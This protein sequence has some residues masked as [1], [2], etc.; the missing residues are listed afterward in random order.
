MASPRRRGGRLAA[1]LHLLLLALVA[2]SPRGVAAE[3]ARRRHQHHAYESTAAHCAAAGIEEECAAADAYGDA[4]AALAAHAAAMAAAETTTT[5]TIGDAEAADA[6]SSSS[7]ATPRA[8]RVGPVA[9]RLVALPDLHGDLD[10][11]RRSLILAR[12]I[13]TTSIEETSVDDDAW[14]GGE[15]ILV[16]TGDVL[17]RGDASVALMRLLDKVRSSITLVP[18]RPRRRGERRSLRTF[19][20]GASLR[21]SGSL[22]G[23]DPRPR[24]LSTPLLTPLNST[25]ASTRLLNKLARAAKDAGGEVVGLLGNHELMTLQGDLRYVSKRELV[26]LGKAALER[27]AQ[28]TGSAGARDGDAATQTEE[29]RRRWCD[30]IETGPHTTPHAR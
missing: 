14:S 13:N 5:T 15:T 9:R 7:A 4:A 22:A 23:F 30:E 3:D 8:A 17:D 10:L 25:V 26:K 24:R 11:A 27:R 12:V 28:Q 20:P 16:Q 1:V 21:P 6:A 18:I 19:S 2:T 29:G